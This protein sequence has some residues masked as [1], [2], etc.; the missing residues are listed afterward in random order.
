[1]RYQEHYC[2]QTSENT[3]I[4]PAQRPNFVSGWTGESFLTNSGPLNWPQFPGRFVRSHSPES[5][6]TAECRLR[7]PSRRP[8][9]SRPTSAADGSHDDSGRLRENA[10]AKRSNLDAGDPVLTKLLVRRVD[11]R[12][13]AGTLHEDQLSAVP[14]QGSGEGQ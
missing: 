3:R 6:Q 4:R 2:W 5:S 7:C 9:R 14:K 12:L 8:E 13:S 11:L 10:L 1:M